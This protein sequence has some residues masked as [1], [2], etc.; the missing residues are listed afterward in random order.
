MS[1]PAGMP[2]AVGDSVAALAGRPPIVTMLFG[3]VARGDQDRQSDLDVLIVVGDDDQARGVRSHFAD[4]AFSAV[5]PLVLSRRAMVEEVALRPSFVSHLLDEGNIVQQTV[6]WISLRHELAEA[7]S[8]PD[9][10]NRE[11]K[12]RARAIESFASPERFLNSPITALSHMYA[13][14]RSLVIA[15]LL[16][17][18][19]REYSWQRAF[20]RYSELHPELRT[21]VEALK[22]LRPFYEFAR[23]RPGARRP[24][25]VVDPEELRYLV[26]SVELIAR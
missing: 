21:E 12:R 8:D 20:D 19:V 1:D 22:A 5:H 6:E 9:L 13:I 2:Q 17:S 4:A 26:R 14:A 16:Q 11:V 3:S 23:A 18:G 24:D 7:A 10:L 25:R 15:R